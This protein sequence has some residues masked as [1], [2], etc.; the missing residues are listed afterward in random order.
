[1]NDESDHTIAGKEKPDFSRRAPETVLDN[2]RQNG[3]DHSVHYLIK[4]GTKRKVK[5]LST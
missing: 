2:V 5:R 3:D 1:M 4:F